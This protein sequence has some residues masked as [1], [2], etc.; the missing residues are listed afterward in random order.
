MKIVR[1]GVSKASSK[2][3]LLGD[4]LRIARLENLQHEKFKG[5]FPDG[6]SNPGSLLGFEFKTRFEPGTGWA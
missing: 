1:D 3:H 2:L 5:S 4:L 6:E